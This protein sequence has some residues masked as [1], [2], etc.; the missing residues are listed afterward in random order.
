MVGKSGLLENSVFWRRRG[1]RNPCRLK[2]C[3]WG[4]GCGGGPWGWSNESETRNILFLI[5]SAGT[6]SSR[7]RPCLARASWS[8]QAGEVPPPRVPTAPCAQRP[9]ALVRFHFDCRLTLDGRS[10]RT[11]NVFSFCN[12]PSTTKFLRHDKTGQHTSFKPKYP[13]YLLSSADGMLGKSQ[14]A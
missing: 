11:G 10:L 7:G 1:A 8:F 6:S 3:G 9:S 13:K 2:M 5:S 4:A 14:I 12:T